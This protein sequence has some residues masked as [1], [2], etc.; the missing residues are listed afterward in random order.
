MLCAKSHL[1]FQLRKLPMVPGADLHP[2]VPGNL[3]VPMNPNSP[4]KVLL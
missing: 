3:R 4:K 2:N 1:P